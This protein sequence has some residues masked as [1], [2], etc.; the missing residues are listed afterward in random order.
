MPDESDCHLVLSFK[1]VVY[2]VDYCKSSENTC[3]INILTTQIDAG[4]P[5]V[6]QWVTNLPSI[7]ENAGLI[8][9]LAQWIQDPELP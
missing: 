9:A 4:V 1:Y 3:L 2:Q 5:V 7:H 8:P 6:A